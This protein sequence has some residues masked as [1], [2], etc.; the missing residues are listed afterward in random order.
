MLHTRVCDLLHITHPI[1]SGGM[2]SWT[3]VALVSSV[4]NAGGL[5][6]IGATLSSPAQI[7]EQVTAV[8]AATSKP[9]GVNFLLFVIEQREASFAAALEARPPVIS[10]AWARPDQD[11]RAYVQRA[12]E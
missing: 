12:H 2:G 1:V 9:F 11:L 7:R 5:G 4:S 8:R 6:V 3:S 10:F